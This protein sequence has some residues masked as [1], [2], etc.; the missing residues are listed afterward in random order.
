MSACPTPSELADFALGKLSDSAI[1]CIAD[2][3]A[4]C[5]PCRIVVESFDDLSD[6]LVAAVR[7]GGAGAAGGR[8]PDS[9][10]AE[11]GELA[12][13]ADRIGM[14][15]LGPPSWPDLVIPTG[16]S[17]SI[18]SR[19]EETRALEAAEVHGAD[20]LSGEPRR[21][22]QYLLIER[23]GQGAMGAVYRARHTSLKRTVAVKILPPARMHDEQAVMRFRREMEAVGQLDHPNIV[24]AT[25]AGHADGRH[26]LAME[27]IEGLDL[28]RL[29]IARGPLSI[30]DACEM[31]RQAAEGLAHA[32][33]QGLVHRDIKP[34]NLILD[35]R[36]CVKV[37]DL[38]L[39]LLADSI[40]LNLSSSHRDSDGPPVSVS[41][42]QESVDPSID[43][44]SPSQLLGTREYMP[45][46]QAVSSHAVDA[47]GDVY[48]LGCTLFR[49]LAGTVPFPREAYASVLA[50][51][52]AVEKTPPP[53]LASFRQD[54]PPLLVAIVA[55][56]L[57][58]RPEDRFASAAEA[59]K[60]LAPFCTGHDLPRLL[61]PAPPRVGAIPPPAE[62]FVVAQL[63]DLPP[64]ASAKSPAGVMHA[65][66]P[67]KPDLVLAELSDSDAKIRRQHWLTGIAALFIGAVLLGGLVSVAAAAYLFAK[68][69]PPGNDKAASS[70]ANPPESIRG[71]M[72]V[73]ER[74]GA[75]LPPSSWHVKL[76]PSSRIEIAN[77]SQFL[78]P[79]KQPF[80][81]EM[82]LR[83]GS[84]A[85]SQSVVAFRPDPPP[86]DASPRRP[87]MGR[88]VGLRSVPSPELGGMT[89]QP[90]G[91]RLLM[92]SPI[93]P[94]RGLGEFEFQDG[95]RFG[96]MGSIGGPPSHRSIASHP[97]WHHVALCVSGSEA[98]VAV[99]GVIQS[100]QHLI[101]RVTPPW[102]AVSTTGALI[103]GGAG[104][105]P[106]T[107]G[108][109]ADVRAVRLSLHCRYTRDFEPP[110]QLKL[111]AQTAA[112]LDFS[113]GK[114]QRLDDLSGNQ[115]H[116]ALYGASWAPISTEGS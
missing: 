22:G 76:G 59:A 29:A 107:S 93:G 60:A 64:G 68:G 21:L 77:S 67:A 61:Q 13:R 42:E 62:A 91:W 55:K 1:G 31:I 100:R 109:T 71:N 92:R 44:T 66:M 39:A 9:E 50:H 115:R 69:S 105:D 89:G 108:L 113:A 10:A 72:S 11:L 19:L 103:I 16:E 96:R 46:E 74:N 27:Y 20:S 7:I 8:A 99:D 88:G 116:G 86:P 35:R 97:G 79:H 43:P 48:S 14:L 56:M 23:I 84:G 51:L 30:A 63:A 94:A 58:K 54:A 6:E 98:M 80:T 26:F 36:G 4:L 12:R 34:S 18:L 110:S 75:A 47:R 106:F 25:D 41:G 53:S 102:E 114:G 2:H 33:A 17:P 70:A 111:D 28:H 3:L 73:S 82:L 52:R 83:A 112:L 45:P 49:L 87:Y 81:V 37:L 95:S 65:W 78:D 32:H 101:P 5:S 15:T 38:G 90:E 104:Q 57:A 24:R 40:D 85:G